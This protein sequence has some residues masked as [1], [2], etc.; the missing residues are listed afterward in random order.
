MS[1]DIPQM[2]IPD[3]S[4]EARNLEAIMVRDSVS[5]AEA[6]LTALR[7]MD[8]EHRRAQPRAR[9]DKPM[10]GDLLTD[11]LIN[12]LKALDTSYGL[13]EDVPNEK[14]ERMEAT[15]RRMKREGFPKRA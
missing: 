7:G 4:A 14:I 1:F 9:K 13:L 15:I 11:E 3:N 12:Q 2:H 6:V 5:P 10:D 8:V